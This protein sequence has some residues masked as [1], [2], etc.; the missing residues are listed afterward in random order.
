MFGLSGIRTFAASEQP[1]DSSCTHR[2]DVPF[3][4]SRL[5]ANPPRLFA[6]HL[7]D[8]ADLFLGVAFDLLA[9]AFGFQSGVSDRLA[10]RFL[11]L[12]HKNFCGAFDLILGARF[13]ID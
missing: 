9:I 2:R 4:R 5:Q 13:H 3:G 11:D 7:L 1:V 10:G 8:L 6:E 12:A